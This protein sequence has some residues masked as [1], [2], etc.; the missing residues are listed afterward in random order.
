M[1]NNPIQW[2]M[3]NYRNIP[4]EAQKIGESSLK[5]LR[6][7]ITPEFDAMLPALLDRACNGD[8]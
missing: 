2:V 1:G 5:H 7:V 3:K 8:S 4:E 6:L